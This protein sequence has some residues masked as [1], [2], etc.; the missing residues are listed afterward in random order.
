MKR[1]L[2]VKSALTAAMLSGVV[3]SMG[4]SAQ[5]ASPVADQGPG[6]PPPP[7]NCAVVAEG[8][9][10]PRFA[11]VGDD[12]SVYVT[13]VGVGGDEVLEMAAPGSG[14]NEET[15]ASPVASD[16][17]P[18]AEE[19]AAPPA[20]R[21]YTGQVTKI[22]PD[23]TQS[24]LVSGLPSYSDG[25]GPEGI[26]FADGMPYVAIGGVADGAGIT[27]LPEEN[28]IYQIDP[29]TG[30][31][32][33]LAQIGPYEVMNNPDGTD[34]NPNLYD[35]T[36]AG[37]KL[38]V[39]DAGGNAIYEVDPAT[40]EF[41]LF[42]VVPSLAQLTGAELEQDRQPVPTGLAPAADGGLYVSLLSEGWPADAPSILHLSLDGTFS[43]VATGLGAVVDV[44]VGPDG[45]VYATQLTTDFMTM[46]PGNVVVI[47]ESGAATPVVDGLM[48]PH[49]AAW[50]A[51]GSLYVTSVS[52]N[53]AP[54]PMG[55]L[56]SCTLGGGDATPEA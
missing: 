31:A 24:V 12:G 19:E 28:T 45:A 33:I 34:V 15:A 6:L 40:G 16:A 53:I 48:L 38:Y 11:A 21:G 13:E 10:V 9:W 47:D 26:V 3:F 29:A 50:G 7:V 52:I 35:I 25:V 17:T 22:A 49:G 39:A 54:E 51:D 2:M 36:Y 32:S 55:A 43:E 30:E 18:V 5:E 42:A 8:L 44:S 20:T 46:A 1:D 4:A 14:T 41:S 56:L 27:P 23:G 37:G